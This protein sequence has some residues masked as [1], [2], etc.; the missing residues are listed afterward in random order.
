MLLKNEK[1]LK[2]FKNIMQQFHLSGPDLTPLV[3][4]YSHLFYNNNG[5]GSPKQPKFEFYC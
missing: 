3:K 1:F 5:N 4:H 2:V